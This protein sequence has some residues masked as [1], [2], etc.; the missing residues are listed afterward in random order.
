MSESYLKSDGYFQL[1]KTTLDAND[2]RVMET[3]GALRELEDG[4]AFR[5]VKMTGASATEGMV[6]V[7]AAVVAI[8]STASGGSSVENNVVTDSAG[9]MTIN[10]YVGYYF[11]VNT[12]GTGS[13]EARKIVAN[14]ATTLTLER[15]LGTAASADSAEIIA[16]L[17]IVVK[18]TAADLDIAVSGVAWGAI[19]QNY[20]GWVQVRGYA[21]VLST[22]ALT[23]GLMTSSGGATLAGQAADYAAANDNYIGTAVAAGGVNNFQL[24]DL[25][26][27]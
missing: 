8:T 5:Y 14:T 15:P 13:E 25:M 18:C 6:L 11:K 22:A 19:T 21:N 27:A 7:P 10:Q 4:R 12:G 24:V 3:I 26:I 9:A 23:E 1:W 20:Y 17:G 2:S 16:P